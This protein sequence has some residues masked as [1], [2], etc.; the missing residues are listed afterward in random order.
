MNCTR[1][2]EFR[3]RRARHASAS[4]PA[5]SNWN[6]LKIGAAKGSVRRRA[7]ER[8][9]DD[10]RDECG[11][12]CRRRGLRHVCNRDAVNRGSDDT[13]SERQPHQVARRDEVVESLAQRPGEGLVLDPDTGFEVPFLGRPGE[14]RPSAVGYDS[15]VAISSSRRAGVRTTLRYP[16]VPALTRITRPIVRFHRQCRQPQPVRRSMV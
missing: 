8:Y 9:Q 5:F 13:V 14:V 1:S 6:R 2:S 7:A 16:F 12:G 4:G 15:V 10:T 11:H 3:F